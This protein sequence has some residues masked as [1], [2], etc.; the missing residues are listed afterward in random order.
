ML[1]SKKTKKMAKGGS[2]K[3][4]SAASEARPMPS[5]RDKDSS[6]VAH[7]SGNK[8]SKNDSWTD[9][10]TIKQAQKPSLTK[11][12]RPRMVGSDGFS[13]RDRA[14]VDKDLTRMDSEAPDGYGAQPR[15]RYD[16][17]MA[18]S[19]GSK[20]S[21][22]Q[23]QHNNHKAPYEKAVE[24][25][26]ADDVAEPEMKQPKRYA[27]GG[28]VKD[29][30]MTSRPDKG[31]GAIIHKPY[32]KGGSIEAESK[33]ERHASIAAAIMAK[34]Q[35]AAKLNSDS[36][37]DE[38]VLMAEG[39][40]VDIESNGEEAPNAYYARN[41]AILKENY[42][43]GMEDAKQPVDSNE[44]GDAREDEESNPNDMVSAIMKKRKAK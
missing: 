27:I 43:D 36:D 26:Y 28:D 42:D 21:D 25:Q 20:V 38:M 6:E 4:E 16:E 33:E 1:Y 31:W 13:V 40:Q 29:E 22:M 5:E 15:K 39:G 34:R 3:N 32:A 10:S 23:A 7:N 35:A 30:E 17:E 44:R 14:D 11:L 18:A 41:Q 9:N 12:S 8:P 19:S 24:S 2:V 37:M